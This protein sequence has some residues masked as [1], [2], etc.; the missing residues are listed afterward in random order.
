MSNRKNGSRFHYNNL[1][2]RKMLA[3]DVTAFEF[4]GDLFIRGDAQDNQ[5][6]IAV[7]DQGQ[8]KITGLDE[9][10]VN[11]G[12]DFIVS[13][14]DSAKFDGGLRTNL[15][16]GNDR[17]EIVDAQFAGRS[18]VYG[19][20]GDDVIDLSGASFQDH[21]TIQTFDGD[22]TISVSD[23]VFEDDL[24]VFSLNGRDTVE[25]ENDTTLG[26]AVV[27]TGDDA[28][29]VKV[30]TNDWLGETQLVLTGDGDDVVEIDSPK[31]GSGGFGVYA[32]H[33]ADHVIADF[34][35]TTTQGNIV[36]NG[37]QGR[38][39][40]EMSMNEELSD[41]ILPLQFE[42]DNELVF[43]SNVGGAENV[44]FG[45]FSYDLDTSDPDANFGAALSE[46]FATPVELSAD[47]TIK[48]IEWTGF[49][50]RDFMPSNL[51]D[52]GDSFVVEI[53]KDAGDGAPDVDS[54]VR[55][56]LGAANRTDT[57]ETGTSVDVNGNLFEY[58]IYS[59]SAN[60]DYE[61]EAGTRYWVSIFTELT[62]VEISESNYWS[63]GGITADDAETI[64][65]RG[66]IPNDTA[67]LSNEWRFGGPDNLQP[68][69]QS[70][71]EF[72]LRVRT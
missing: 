7:D 46:R 59:Y 18:V 54:V 16:R 38:D 20:R 27:V 55:Y 24:F 56:E 1:E 4:G 8:I 33:G 68:D 40:V 14:S 21:I 29:H 23:S 72:D 47:E 63:W 41:Q 10:T 51:P 66:A 11:R 9:T 25:L 15:G 3:G 30:V 44:F 22:D 35:E 12:T 6:Q 13:G 53:F 34:G 45:L 28:D 43:Q 17:F 70:F 64:I 57:G 61:F 49:Y 60:V 52:R 69:T 58:P 65:Y 5:I 62:D 36:V 26:T 42:A 37:Q 19:G 67:S 71:V 48:S 50:E 31:V 39:V 2:S 32:G